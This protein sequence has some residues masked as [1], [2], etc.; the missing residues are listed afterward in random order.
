MTPASNVE[1][2]E[3]MNIIIEGM[4]KERPNKLVMN[5]K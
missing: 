1:Y 3:S 2:E 5:L 4:W